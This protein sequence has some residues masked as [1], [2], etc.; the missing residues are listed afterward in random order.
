MR[1][2][3][4]T[5]RDGK[6]VD[7]EAPPARPSPEASPRIEPEPYGKVVARRR[8]VLLADVGARVWWIQR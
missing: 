7:V 8:Q 1:L 4:S 2:S 6:W 3:I 5:L